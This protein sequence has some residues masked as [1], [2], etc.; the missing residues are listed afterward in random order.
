ME[1]YLSEN[2]YISYYFSNGSCLD[3][4][5]IAVYKEK[6]ILIT[7]GNTFHIKG[8]TIY[9][10]G[11]SNSYFDKKRKYVFENNNFKEIRQPYYS[12]GMKGTLNVPIKI[13]QTTEYKNEIAVLPKGYEV[14]IILVET[15]GEYDFIKNV[16]IKTKFGLIGWFDFDKISLLNVEL[17]D[18]F[19]YH[20]D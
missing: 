16:L 7:L 17:I 14:E 20:G 3:P 11:V 19:I 10:E 1:S 2:D 15:E 6:I 13:Y 8:K 9:V 4:Q 5:L 18:G 12:V